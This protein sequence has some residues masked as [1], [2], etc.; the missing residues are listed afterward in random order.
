MALALARLQLLSPLSPTPPPLHGPS[1]SLLS[2]PPCNTTMPCV[3]SMYPIAPSRTEMAS[4]GELYK[5]VSTSDLKDSFILHHTTTTQPQQPLQSLQSLSFLFNFLTTI[6]TPQS[7]H[8]ILFLAT[9]VP[10][11]SLSNH[12][13]ASPFQH[14]QSS[15]SKSRCILLSPSL[16]RL[17]PPALLRSLT[18]SRRPPLLM[19]R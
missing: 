3:T 6:A 18:L 9:I 2:P 16:L 11:I 17:L 1:V 7:L 10:I 15:T 12:L 14:I 8:Q 5:R 19:L 4:P 13:S